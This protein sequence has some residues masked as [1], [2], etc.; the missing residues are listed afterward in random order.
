VFIERFKWRQ[1]QLSLRKHGIPIRQGLKTF[2]SYL[3]ISFICFLIL[4]KRVKVP[5]SYQGATSYALQ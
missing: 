2:S 4:I 5:F 1:E 3:G